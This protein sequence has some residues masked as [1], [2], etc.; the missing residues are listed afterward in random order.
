MDRGTPF[1]YLKRIRVAFL[2]TYPPRECGIATYTENLLA[3]ISR[4]HVLN[5]PAVLAINDKG[6]FYDY[7]R[8]VEFQIDRDRVESYVEAAEYVN[9]SDIDVVNL[10]HE[11]GLFGGSWGE[12][13]LAFLE[14]LEKPV[15]STLHTLLTEPVPEARRVMRGI[16]SRSDYVIVMARVGMRI[17][18]QRYETLSDRARY[19]PHGCP[20]VPFIS[21]DSV[22]SRLGLGER[23]I[24][25]TFGLLSRG[26]GI[27]Y[28]IRALPKI[29]EEDPRVL[30]LIIG[31]TH[32]EVRKAEGESY[33]KALIELVGNL[34]LEDNVRFVNDFLPLNEL[35]RYLQATD[36]YVIPYPNREQISSGTLLYALSTGKAIVSTPFLHAE[37][38]IA[39]GCAMGC[40][41][42]DPESIT[43]CLRTLIHYDDFHRRLETKAYEYSRGMIW[44]N[45]AMKYVNIFYEALGM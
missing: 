43:R 35:L 20:N 32:P 36:I 39:E 24:I 31:E 3:A 17:L 29:V 28:A 11:Y 42:M 7:G 21:S 26:K 6:G 12:H 2:S 9:R 40:D 22:K 25:S 44:P 34:G 10:Q 33:R 30:Y 18:E 13:V 27:E 37:E 4:L 45:V 41:F 8:E 23:T 19:I 5:P 1:D 15:V 38:V 14:R 16:I